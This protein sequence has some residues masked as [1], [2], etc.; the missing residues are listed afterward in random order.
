[1]EGYFKRIPKQLTLIEQSSIKL[2]YCWNCKLRSYWNGISYFAATLSN[3]FKFKGSIPKYFRSHPIYKFSCSCCNA[4]YY[5]ETERHL[6][7]RALEHLGITPLKQ[8]RVKN[9][10]KSAIMDKE[11]ITKF[12]KQDGI[13][14]Q[15]QILY[16]IWKI[17][18]IFQILS[19]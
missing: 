9:P 13:A 11:N 1:M 17:Y 15:R 6:F 18:V 4:T 14:N 3:L 10:K 5:G 8:K 2:V 19:E 16:L 12:I 7:V